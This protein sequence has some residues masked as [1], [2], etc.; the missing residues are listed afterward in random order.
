MY[1]SIALAAALALPMGC[2]D[3]DR[4]DVVP[5]LT[6]GNCQTKESGVRLIDYATLATFRATHLIGMTESAEAT[7]NPLHLIAI[8]PGEYPTPGYTV[9]LQA[10]PELTGGAMTLKVKV[11]HPA[12]DAIL[13]QMIT[14]PCLVVGV[15]DPAVSH[16]RV[17]D[18]NAVVLGEVDLPK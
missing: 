13:A 15:A 10:A 16:V 8:V 9:A 12:K 17:L 1:R 7:K 6:N 4:I 3:A 5:V 14:H 18:E 11:E 2:A